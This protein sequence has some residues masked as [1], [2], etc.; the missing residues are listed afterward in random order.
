MTS[1]A[2]ARHAGSD[3]RRRKT[4]HASSA[5]ASIAAFFDFGSSRHAA[6][7]AES[8]MA[9]SPASRLLWR[10][11]AAPR[12]VAASS[13]HW[14]R[15]KAPS[16]QGPTA[17][18]SGRCFA[19][20]SAHIA[21]TPPLR[22]RST[23][24]SPD[25]CSAVASRARSSLDSHFR[26]PEQKSSTACKADPSSAVPIKSCI[27]SSTPSAPL[28]SFCD[29]AASFAIMASASAAFLAFASPDS[30]LCTAKTSVALPTTA[31]SVLA[32]C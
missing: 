4:A 19:P 8:K 12:E 1:A 7:R 15:S 9:R 31:A 29:H 27:I 24:A 6:A 25:A 23:R 20:S 14:S 18:A 11:R 16:A 28:W 5:P 32:S 3:S 17:P 2:A 21:S 10:C 26:A 30:A 13:S 22:R